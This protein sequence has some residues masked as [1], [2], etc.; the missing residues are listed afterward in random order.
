[1]GAS[2][3][4]PVMDCTYWCPSAIGQDVWQL[5]VLSISY[6]M[7]MVL[8]LTMFGTEV[9][10][11]DYR[12][13]YPS[14]F[15]NLLLYTSLVFVVMR[16][17]LFL[18]PFKYNVFSL[19]L[20]NV[21]MPMF[22]QFFTFSLL[23]LFLIK[24][25]LIIHKAKEAWTRYLYTGYVIFI[26]VTFGVVV[27][28]SYL[29]SEG[30]AEKMLSGNFTVI[31]TPSKADVVHGNGGSIDSSLSIW[32]SC[33]FTS[34]VL[35]VGGMGFN[36]YRMTRKIALSERKRHQVTRFMRLVVIYFGTFL[37][38]SVWNIL[39]VFD[40]NPLQNWIIQKQHDSVTLGTDLEGV[41][42][43]LLTF[44]LLLE[45]VPTTLLVLSFRGI[46]EEGKIAQSQEQR[47]LDFTRRQRNSVNYGSMLA[48]S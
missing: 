32:T 23:V 20:L 21:N 4:T 26:F 46:F 7:I 9:Y 41:F 38:R 44:Y 34:L 47:K 1:M 17:V 2:A 36:T 16:A 40:V 48:P 10:K 39:N 31:P 14:S 6:M 24:C 3:L 45:V 5:Y 29:L 15:K 43:V 37:F 11:G 13:I 33:A 35:I 27:F 18:L 12:S 22:L 28:G 30:I 25:Q 19:V 8:I 42:S